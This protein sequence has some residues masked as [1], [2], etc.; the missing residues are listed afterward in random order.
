LRLLL[1]VPANVTLN[2]GLEV[3]D[4]KIDTVTCPALPASGFAPD[5]EV[6]CTASYIV[7]QDDIDAGVI[8]NI[9]S[10]AIGSTR[11]PSDSVTV[12]ATQSAALSLTK[13]V[14]QSDYETPGDVLEM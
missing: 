1:Q 5:T 4:D 14:A 10:A 7:T 6:S 8:T 13:S 3:S 2:G 12:T 9:A 11:S